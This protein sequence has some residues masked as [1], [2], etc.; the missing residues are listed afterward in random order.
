MTVA[1]IMN[2]Y[3]GEYTYLEVYKPIGNR[4]TFHTDN[5]ESVGNRFNLDDYVLSYELMD[6]EEY[7]NTILA[8]CGVRFNDCYANSDIILVV[9]I[10]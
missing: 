1:E 3:E 7:E 10:K 4:H 5:I 8:N 9:L 2:S 6:K